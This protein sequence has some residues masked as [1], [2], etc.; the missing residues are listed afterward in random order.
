M[1]IIVSAWV[2][3]LLDPLI[4]LA[5][6]SLGTCHYKHVGSSRPTLAERSKASVILDR[7]RGW[8]FKS[9]RCLILLDGMIGKNGS[10]EKRR[11]FDNRSNW[12]RQTITTYN[13][14]KKKVGI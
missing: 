6:A 12:K 8:R 2:D 10:I 3:P 7:G 4:I 1:Q 13:N 14:G 9:R 5:K 11:Q